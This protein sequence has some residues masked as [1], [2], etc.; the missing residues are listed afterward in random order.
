MYQSAVALRDVLGESGAPARYHAVPHVTFTDPEV[1]GVGLTEQQARDAGL[2]VRTGSTPLEQSSRGF[3]HGPGG[4]GLI[5]VVEDAEI[6]ECWWE[7]L[8]SVLQAARSSASWPSRCT[9][10]SRSTP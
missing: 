8:P 4:R 2:R 5:K 9:R 7:R 6:A 1:A 10:R 3:T